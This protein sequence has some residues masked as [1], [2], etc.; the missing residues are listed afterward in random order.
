MGA[1]ATNRFRWAKGRSSTLAVGLAAVLRTTADAAGRLTGETLLDFIEFALTA[2]LTGVFA[3]ERFLTAR[4]MSS[5]LAC[6]KV[7]GGQMG[8]QH[9]TLEQRVDTLGR[10]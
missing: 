8:V 2:G 1:L 7:V 5:M 9:S 3:D 10:T 4:G 6:I